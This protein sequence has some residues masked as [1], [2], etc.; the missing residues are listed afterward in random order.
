MFIPFL[1]SSWSAI[2]KRVYYVDPKEA[3]QFDVS[4]F[5]ASAQDVDVKESKTPYGTQYAVSASIHFNNTLPFTMSFQ[6]LQFGCWVYYK[7]VPIVNVYTKSNAKLGLNKGKNVV[8]VRALTNSLYTFQLMELIGR[9]ADGE[10]VPVSVKD[11]KF[12]GNVKWQWVQDM[13]DGWSI[14]VIIPGAKED[15]RLDNDLFPFWV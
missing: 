1:L 13:V 3:S 9:V 6:P 8:E 7:N 4:S 12:S 14:P 11:I 15:F 2:L 10:D 5:N